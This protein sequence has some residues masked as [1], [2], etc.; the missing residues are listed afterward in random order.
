MA[1]KK[2][3]PVE[4]VVEKASKAFVLL[5]GSAN[6]L[7]ALQWAKKYYEEVHAI[8]F[9]YKKNLENEVFTARIN[10]KKIGVASHTIVNIPDIL[11]ADQD[12]YVYMRDM[13]FLNIAGNHAL[14]IDC[15]TLVVGIQKCNYESLQMDAIS[16]AYPFN[17]QAPLIYM[18]DEEVAK[19]AQD[20]E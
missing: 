2:A 20:M 3:K 15:D 8:T 14:A 11:K 9:N 10:A 12:G 7:I 6:S 19:F 18:D 13:V 5:S 4:N 17:I 1:K 16:Q